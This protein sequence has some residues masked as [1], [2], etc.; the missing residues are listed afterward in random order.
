[1]SSGGVLKTIKYESWEQELKRGTSG[2]VA[3]EHDVSKSP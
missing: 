2:V 1:M 3:F